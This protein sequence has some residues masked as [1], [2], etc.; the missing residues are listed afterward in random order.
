MCRARAMAIVDRGVGDFGRN[1][2]VTMSAR[3][4][5]D[6]AARVFRAMIKTA[7]ANQPGETR[8]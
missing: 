8:T 3:L 6:E 2:C 4:N 7:L 1:D 5:K